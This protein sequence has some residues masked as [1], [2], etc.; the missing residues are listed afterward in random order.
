LK[1]IHSKNL[2]TKNRKQ[3]NERVREESV[4]ARLK[5]KLRLEHSGSWIG[6]IKVDN[7]V[8]GVNI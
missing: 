7:P 8:D 5:L 4:G 1:Q 2:K 6:E 3:L